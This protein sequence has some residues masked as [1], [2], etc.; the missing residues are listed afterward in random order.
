MRSKRPIPKHRPLNICSLQAAKCPM[1]VAQLPSGRRKQAARSHGRRG[2]LHLASATTNKL[3][4]GSI[5]KLAA[6][7]K[8]DSRLGISPPPRCNFS[9]ASATTCPQ[10]ASCASP[11][12][13]APY[14]SVLY[15]S[16]DFD[17]LK[18]NASCAHSY[19]FA[20]CLAA[21]IWHAAGRCHA[22]RLRDSSIV[23]GHLGSRHRR[24]RAAAS[25]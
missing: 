2:Q 7:P 19:P 6:S 3:A 20:L 5:P 12:H 24:Q 1:S 25:R 14:R 9:A 11:A 10:T 22:C 21:P 18:R 23:T 17:N 16:S 8:P 15:R 13:V 4:S